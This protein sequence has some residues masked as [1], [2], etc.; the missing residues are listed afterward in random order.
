MYRFSRESD[1]QLSTCHTDLQRLFREVIKHWD[2]K[3]LNGKRTIERQ[4][5]NVAK[6]VSKTLNSKHVYPIL[7]PSLAVDVVPYPL[8]WPQPPLDDSPN[9]LQRWMKEYALFYYF[10]GF[11]LGVAEKMGIAIRHGGD[12]D[13]DRDVQDQSFNDLAHFELKNA[14]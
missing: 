13:G 4:R 6:G 14:L 1:A 8:Q 11:V 7:E 9:E 3:V 2:C 10:S 12:W 5:M